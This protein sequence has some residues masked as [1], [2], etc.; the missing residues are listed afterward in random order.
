VAKKETAHGYKSCNKNSILAADGWQYAFEWLATRKRKLISSCIST[1]Q[2]EE[3]E[4][5]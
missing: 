4:I 2:F 3:S 1:F 5:R